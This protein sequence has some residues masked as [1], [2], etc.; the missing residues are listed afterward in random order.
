VFAT[1]ATLTLAWSLYVDDFLET[2]LTALKPCAGDCLNVYDPAQWSAVRWLTCLM[3]GIFSCLPLILLQTLRFSKPGLLPTEYSALKRWLSLTT[4]LLVGGTLALVLEGLPQLY[5]LGYEQHQ[6]AGLSAQYSAVDMLMVA[7]YCIWAFTVVVA[8]WNALTMMGLF[9]V[10]NAQTADYWRLRLYGVG[11]I[12]LILSIPEH[13]ASMLLP[14]LATYWTSC[15][16]LGQRWFNTTV[17]VHGKAVVRLDAE[18]RRRRVALADCSC[19]GAN[20]HHGHAKVQG[21]STV[22]VQ[23]LC[24]DPFSRTK[25]IEHA[26][27]SGLTDI[28]ITGC[29]GRPCPS[30][31]HQNMKELD[32][33]VHGLDLMNI[34]NQRVL[35]P[36]PEVDVQAAFYSM[37]SLFTPAV[38]DKMLLELVEE[39]SWL[40]GGVHVLSQDEATTWDVYRPSHEIII[41]P[42]RTIGS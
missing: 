24:T 11:S 14:L 22:S 13:A 21:C 10:L 35:S 5:Q 39:K 25:L 3:L 31:F 9:G 12:L 30:Q 42:C 34:Q 20:Y 4:V 33:R 41:P 15:E 6:E 7:A 37:S 38:R 36:H 29:D 1:I 32:V 2:V 28:V 17:A 40:K 8:T 27:Q 19:E 18:G 16:L 23:S 26:L